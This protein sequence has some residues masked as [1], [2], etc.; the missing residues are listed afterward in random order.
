MNK[1]GENFCKF[2][3][4][5]TGTVIVEL[6][7][8]ISLLNFFL[9]SYALCFP[10]AMLWGGSDTFLQTNMGAII[11]ALFPGQVESFSVYRIFFALGTVTTIVLNLALDSVVAWVFLI[12]VLAITLFYTLVSINVMELKRL[13]RS[14]L[15]ER[16]ETQ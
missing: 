3:L 14:S 2:K 11:S 9:E 16:D 10:I 12:I 13:T 4:A 8:I 15:L 6:A 1:F 7:G 5:I